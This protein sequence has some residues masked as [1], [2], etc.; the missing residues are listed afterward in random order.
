MSFYH[1]LGTYVRADGARARWRLCDIDP[2]GAL[3]TFAP[4]RD[5][6]TPRAL[7]PRGGAAQQAPYGEWFDSTLIGRGHIP[8]QR[9]RWLTHVLRYPRS[10]RND[11]IARQVVA[12]MAS[13]DVHFRPWSS[14]RCY[15]DDT[16]EL[17]FYFAEKADA[18]LFMMFRESPACCDAA[19]SQRRGT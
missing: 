9:G 6:R 19:P 10:R 2:T 18:A 4:G 1:L 7:Y 17:C 5:Q 12:Q 13:F 8:L 14:G 11:A 15:I 3:Q 16:L